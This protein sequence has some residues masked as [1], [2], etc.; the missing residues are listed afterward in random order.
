[1][2]CLH[3]Y[4]VLHVPQEVFTLGPVL[5]SVI[6]S[7]IQILVFNLVASSPVSI[8]NDLLIRKPN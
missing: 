2:F 5:T 6:D 8:S 4:H 3:L 7:V 1:M